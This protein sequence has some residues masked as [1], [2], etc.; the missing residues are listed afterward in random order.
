[1][2]PTIRTAAQWLI[3]SYMISLAFG[4]P[5]AYAGTL[6][7]VARDPY[8]GAIVID[9]AKGKVIFEDNADEKGYPA[10]MLKLMNLLVILEKVNEGVLHLNDKVP[11]TAEASRMGGTQVWLK[12][13][14]VFTIDELLYALIVRSANDAAVALAIHIAG[15]KDAF[16]ELM[17]QRAEELGMKSTQFHSVHG[18]P[19]GSDQKPDVTTARDMAIL[20]REVLKHPDALRYTSILERGFRDNTVIMRSHNPLL[21]TFEG[22]D[23]LKT[24]YFF[25][26]GF[27][28][29]ATAR[30]GDARVIA[31]VLGS[32]TKKIR[33]TKA[34]E[35]LA[36]GFLAIPRKAIKP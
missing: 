11:V 32:T 30:R 9:N 4:L 10:S 31:V 20:S 6:K 7:R 33:N 23:G 19:P 18:L 12:E 15:S 17:N 13:N 24:G 14:E 1:M 2:K 25:A 28:I 34:A 8:V 16:V 27:S 35:L 26:A 29:A 3:V 36:R 21:K 5:P 22:C